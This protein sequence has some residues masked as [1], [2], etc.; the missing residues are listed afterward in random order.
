MA[1][2]A[3][4]FN[5]PPGSSY[6][7]SLEADRARFADAYME[8]LR[9]SGIEVIAL[10]DHNTG[11]WLPVMQAAGRRHDIVV[12]PGVEVTTA[13][14]S[15]GAHLVLIGDLDRTEQDINVLLAR[16]CGFDDDHPRLNPR[17]NDPAPAPRT[18]N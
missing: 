15:D 6:D 13:S 14:G 10:A 7:F 16:T 8:R 11:A 4:K 9:E 1:T 3:W 18:V 2:P 5:L 17:T 12:F